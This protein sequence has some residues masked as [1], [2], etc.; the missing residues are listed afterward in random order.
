MSEFLLAMRVG[1]SLDVGEI[2]E[3]YQLSPMA[4]VCLAR[5]QTAGGDIPSARRTLVHGTIVLPGERALKVALLRLP[6]E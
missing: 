3:R 1:G 6:P 2:A 5:A 4:F